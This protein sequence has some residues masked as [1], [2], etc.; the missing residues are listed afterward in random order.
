MEKSD[1]VIYDRMDLLTKEEQELINAARSSLP[2]SYAPY[3]SFHVG[4]AIRLSDGRILTGVNQENASSPAGLCAE[5]VTLYRK[6]VE[7]PRSS[8]VAMAIVAQSDR[9]DELPAISPCG[10]CRQVM[11]EFVHRQNST[12]PVI[13][14]GVQGTWVKVHKMESLLPFGFS[15]NSL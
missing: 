1:F 5:Q 7:A 3:S 12:Y 9:T 11:L 4:A 14:Q 10:N 8:I 6:G 15:S 2:M 13:M